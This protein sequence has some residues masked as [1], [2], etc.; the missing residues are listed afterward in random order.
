MATSAYTSTPETTNANRACRV[1]LGPCTD[2]LR[3]ILRHYVP[4]STFSQV[5]TQNQHKLPRL[6]TVQRDLILPQTGSYTGSYDDMDISLLYLLLR[7]I[8]GISPHSK[9]WGN[10]PDPRDTSLSAS[11]ERIRVV[12][13]DCVHSSDPYMSNSKFASVWSTIRK[14]MVDLDAFLMNGKQYKN[15]VDFLYNESMDPG[16]DLHW[17]EELRKQVKEDEKTREMVDRL[18]GKSKLL[19]HYCILHMYNTITRH[20]IWLYYD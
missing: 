18:Q 10:D 12:R 5:I 20:L 14:V 7:N 19:D 17:E 3:D 1:V 4:P 15:E 13:N 16:R 2:G 6:T 8:T 11:I 9:G